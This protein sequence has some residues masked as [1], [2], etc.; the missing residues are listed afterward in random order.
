MFGCGSDLYISDLCNTKR[1]S[2]AGSIATYNTAD[3]KFQ[4][5]QNAYTAISGATDGCSFRVLEY[6]VFQVLR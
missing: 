4:N 1:S 6:E 2:Y 3:H 5:S